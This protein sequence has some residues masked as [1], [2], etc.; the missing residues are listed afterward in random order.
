MDPQAAQAA[1]RGVWEGL[2]A[3]ATVDWCEENYVVTPYVA[4]FWNTTSSMWM[5]V[6]GAWGAARLASRR[7]FL[8]LF[9]GLALVG[10]GSAAFHGTL[11]RPAQALDELPMVF[12]GMVAVWVVAHRGRE[13]ADGVRVAAALTVYG[14]VFAVAYWTLPWAFTVF[15]AV[16]GGLVTWLTL[17]SLKLTFSADDPRLQNTLAIAATGFFGTLLGCWIPEHVILPCDHPAQALPL[18]ALW[19]LGAGTGTYAFILWMLHADDAAR[20]A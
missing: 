16:Y 20:A 17:T 8:T 15:L 3:P 7:R 10:I 5:C 12:L 18:H 19:H 9:S 13:F 2:A 14:L 1:P 6:L 11:L 4:E